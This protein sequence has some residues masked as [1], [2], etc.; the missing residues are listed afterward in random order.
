MNHMLYFVREK[1]LQEYQSWTNKKLL[2][3]IFCSTSKTITT[4]IA[5]LVFFMC[6]LSNCLLPRATF[7]IP[8]LV[9]VSMSKGR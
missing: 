3:V 1:L 5:P 6:F 4:C 7:P 8:V 9:M 2:F